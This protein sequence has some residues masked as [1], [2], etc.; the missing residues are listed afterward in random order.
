M[1]S[2]SMLLATAA[3]FSQC[4][5]YGHI[6]A[7]QQGDTLEIYHTDPAFAC[8]P[9]DSIR[10]VWWVACNPFNHEQRTAVAV[11][12]PD[13]TLKIEATGW[14]AIWA[15][16]SFFYDSLP[17]VSGLSVSSNTVFFTGPDAPEAVINITPNPSDG[18]F[19]V[20]M[21]TNA[22]KHYLRIIGPW[23]MVYAGWF[24][25]SSEKAFDLHPMNPNGMYTAIVD[26]HFDNTCTGPARTRTKFLVQR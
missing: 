11:T 4:W 23:G 21:E 18:H 7:K 15:T 26:W 3:A 22:P 8:V 9:P 1:I 10:V 24:Q 5:D 16:T 25:G 6:E 12:G 2:M 17:A 20:Q 13:D 19:T 14:R